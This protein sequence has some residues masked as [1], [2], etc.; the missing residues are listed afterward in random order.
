MNLSSIVQQLQA[1]QQHQSFGPAGRCRNFEQRHFFDGK[2][3]L[4]FQPL[5]ERGDYYRG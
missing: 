3:Q 4:H 5:D 1:E 2:H